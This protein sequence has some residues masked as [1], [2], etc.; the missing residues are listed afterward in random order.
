MARESSGLALGALLLG[1]AMLSFGPWLV[2]LSAISPGAS[3]FWRI[4]IALPFL[5]VVA[6]IARQPLPRGLRP[7]TLLFVGG[8][9]FAADLVAWHA[10]ILATRLANATLFGNF[11][12]FVFAGYGFIAARRLPDGRQGIAI[13]LATLGVTLLLGRS[14]ELDPRHLIGDV[15]CMLAGVLYG[16]YLIV[17]DQARGRMASWPV[18]AVASL[19]AAPLLLMFAMA[20]GPVLPEN[21]TPLILLALGSQVVGQGMLVYAVGHLSPLTVGVGLLTQPALGAIIGSTVYGERLGAHD[22]A[23]MVAIGVALVLIR[24]GNPRS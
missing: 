8:F 6:R 20:T 15:L 7:W 9:F 13:L 16:A 5:F 3:A 18:L 17:I 10:G 22:L 2:R 1:N 11:G 14:Y 19:G 12:S 4:A 24:A 21:W 23:G